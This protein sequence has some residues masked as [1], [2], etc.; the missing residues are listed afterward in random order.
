MTAEHRGPRPVNANAAGLARAEVLVDGQHL[1]YSVGGPTDGQPAVFLHGIG[2]S[3]ADW[4]NNLDHFVDQGYRV[5]APDL[6]GRGPSDAPPEDWDP[7]DGGQAVLRMLDAWG[8]GQ[9]VLF[10]HS[11][12]G[13]LALQ[14]ALMAPERVRVLVLAAPAGLERRVGWGMRL[15]SLPLIGKV[16]WRPWRWQATLTL[17]M[18]FADG[19]RVTKEMVDSWQERWRDPKRRA[20]FLRL[21]KRSIRIGGLRSDLILRKDLDR[22][23]QPALVIWG[24]EDVIVPFPKDGHALV[25]RLRNGKLAILSPCGHWPQIEQAEAFNQEASTFLAGLATPERPLEEKNA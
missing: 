2:G 3:S 14:A 24:K 17:R 12:G 19:S 20:W 22:I 7:R 16:G 25:S 15:L 6:P 21:L 18:V 13:L 11:G 10:G 9:A 5:Y 8:I 4:E 1:H 23:E